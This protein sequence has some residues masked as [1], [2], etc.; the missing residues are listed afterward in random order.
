MIGKTSSEYVKR[1]MQKKLGYN[2]PT[3]RDALYTGGDEEE[4]S[5]EPGQKASKLQKKT[6]RKWNEITFLKNEYRWNKTIWSDKKKI[7]QK[8]KEM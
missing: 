1:T 5:L 4:E 7:K 3:K 8:N 2:I 6:K